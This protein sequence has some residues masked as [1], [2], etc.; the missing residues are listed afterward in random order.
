MPLFDGNLA[1]GVALLLAGLLLMITG[2]GH[3]VAVFIW[4]TRLERIGKLSARMKRIAMDI[5][6]SL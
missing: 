4:A 5:I 2:W 1:L 3:T 6:K